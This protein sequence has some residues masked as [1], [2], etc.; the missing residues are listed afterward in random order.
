MTMHRPATQRRPGLIVAVLAMTGVVATGIQTLIVPLLGQLPSLLDASAADTA[1]V[2]TVTLLTSAV[3]VPISGRLG[4]M[5]GKRAVMI[6]SLVPLIA[7][8]VVCALSVSL[9]AMV[10]GRGL[11]GLGLGVVPLGISLLREVM[12]PQRIGSAVAT[13][14]ASMGIGG[15]LGLPFAAIVGQTT[16][17]R[18]MFW[19][20]AGLAVVALALLVWIVPAG[21][22]PTPRPRFDTRGAVGLSLGLV[23]LLLGISKGASWGWLSLPTLTCAG[24]AVVCLA[25]WT[26]HQL[27]AS[28]PLVNLRSLSDRRVALA[29]LVG[30]LI[31][32]CTYP[33]S[34]VIPQILQLPASTGYGL[35]QSMVAMALWLAPGGLAMLAIAPV[36]ARLSARFGP[37]T[38]L[39]LGALVIAA[40]YVSTWWLMGSPWG[41]MIV[42]ALCNVGVGMAY[43]A[44]PL[45]LMDAV[46]PAETASANGF[47]T[48]CRAIGTS[49]AG[50]VI[51]GA[52][53]ASATQVDTFTAPSAPAL[54][55]VLLV[56]VGLGGL[57]CLLAWAIP[58]APQTGSPAPALVSAGPGTRS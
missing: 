20:F 42:V 58:R 11:Q 9:G 3:A 38:T 21:H 26:A 6:A 23:S 16:N 15:A 51:G 46:P 33:L 7:G 45:I 29:N 44:I 40:G 18:L 19:T 36:S 49:V 25:L 56:G 54:H 24:L 43:A 50:A 4:D 13:M 34:Y 27:H 28:A 57:A 37:R 31:S 52:L 32:F 1:W 12:P 47:N 39:S 2:V 14:S 48:L 55:A 5:L 53:A 17:W 10:V 41:L 30:L 35:G 22:R 8:S